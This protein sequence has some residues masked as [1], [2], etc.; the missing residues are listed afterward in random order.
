LVSIRSPGHCWF[1]W[2]LATVAEARGAPLD[3]FPPA[4]EDTAGWA[5][6]GK[7]LGELPLVRFAHWSAG[8][9]GQKW[10]RL[11]ARELGMA[12][13]LAAVLAHRGE[14]VLQDSDELASL[15][16]TWR[17]TASGLP[18]VTA[19]EARRIFEWLERVRE[20]IDAVVIMLTA[21][22]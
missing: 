14:P 9:A 13:R 18:P 15:A 7:R 10:V 12:E 22:E 16:R 2:F 3:R 1:S 6:V 11:Q 19:D 5:I 4:P 21:Q 17:F 20:R 8:I